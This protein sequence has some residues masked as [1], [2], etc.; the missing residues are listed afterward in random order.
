MLCMASIFLNFKIFVGS[1]VFQ[2]DIME[3][4]VFQITLYL[5]FLRPNLF[6]ETDM[7]LFKS[8]IS[9]SSICHKYFDSVKFSPGSGSSFEHPSRMTASYESC[10]E[11]SKN[12]KIAGLLILAKFR[13][14]KINE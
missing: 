3:N 6:Q 10:N 1:K 8:Y 14:M 4:S 11:G 5:E 13:Y 2:N 12:F 9:I 7:F